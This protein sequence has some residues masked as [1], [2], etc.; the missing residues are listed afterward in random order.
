MGKITVILAPE[1]SRTRI[2]VRSG[3]CDMMK[4]VL[5]PIAQA[6]ERAARTLLES[7]S[8]WQQQKLSVVLRVDDPFDGHALG[9]C[10]ALG[11][12]ERSLH[13]NVGVA[14]RPPRRAL[15]GVGDFGDMRR[16]AIEEAV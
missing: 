2:L 1:R 3:D 4:A 13:Y 8:L 14:L 15:H 5:G 10:D 9:L 7:L 11:F 12:G 6:H 16:L